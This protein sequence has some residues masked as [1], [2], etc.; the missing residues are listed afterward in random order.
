MFGASVVATETGARNAESDWLPT[1]ENLS[2]DSWRLLCKAL[3]EPVPVAE[4]H[5]SI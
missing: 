3:E 5:G 1:P 2:D 4:R